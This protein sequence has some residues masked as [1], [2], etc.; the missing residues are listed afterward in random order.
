MTIF[1]P[2]QSVLDL[3]APR[4]DIGGMLNG[5]EVELREVSSYCHD[6]VSGDFRTRL[7]GKGRWVDICIDWGTWALTGLERGGSNPLRSPLDVSSS[8]YSQRKIIESIKWL[9]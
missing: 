3:S 2:F 8:L 9:L 6:S 1:E 7:S 5:H 4:F